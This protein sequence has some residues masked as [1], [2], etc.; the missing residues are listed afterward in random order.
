M[1]ENRAVTDSAR[2]PGAFRSFF[3][4]VIGSDFGTQVSYVA[5]PLTA[6]LAL[7]AGPAEV[8]ALTALTTFAF[9]LI[10]L[11]AGAWVDRLPRRAV[12][13]TSDAVR[14]VLYG[15]VPV[16]WLLGML[17][18]PQLYSVALLGGVATVFSEVAAQTFLPEIVGRA[19][20]VQANARLMGMRG[21]NQIIGRSA[22]G[23]LA[24]AITAPV[25]I[26][27]DAVS[28]AIS[29]VVL[30]RI[31]GSGPAVPARPKS[32]VWPDVRDGLRHVLGHRMLR[33]LAVEGALTNFAS[34]LAIT[35]L[36]V[37]F[38]R[39]LG[40]D[41]WVLGA[42]LA[43][44][45]CGALAGASIARALAAR[46]G[47]G[48]VLWIAGVAASAAGCVVPL[49]GSGAWLWVV[50]AAWS[51]IITKVGI[52][53]V[54]AVS[55]RQ[56]ATPDHLMGRMNATFRFLLTGALAVAAVLAGLL[57]EVAGVRAV[58][59]VS[60]GTFALS[61]LVVFLSPVR[62]LRDLPEQPELERPAPVTPAAGPR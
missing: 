19:K 46:F 17:S 33:P 44:G 40:L 52:G 24:S 62:S 60:A 10:G 30:W 2:L 51:M 18:M 16:A 23:V 57:G 26:A 3:G 32:R 21:V 14:T 6:V 37:L 41:Q 28:Y 29:A 20:L 4:A 45:G 35:V 53:N 47:H 12:M 43:I 38:V 55:L 13:I 50:V 48:R 27:L 39:E 49:L 36:P 8:G 59:W 34:T 15:S 5:L 7:G 42:F 31:K 22:G 11:P 56:S 25:V 54:L 1:I 58:L 61:W 9:L